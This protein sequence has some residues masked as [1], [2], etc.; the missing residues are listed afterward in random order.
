MHSFL[1]FILHFVMLFMTMTWSLHIFHLFLGITFPF[2]SRFLQTKK[3]KLILCIGELI[4]VI[5]LSAIPPAIFLCISEYGIFWYP[6]SH[7]LPRS[8]LG[9]YLLFLP[10]TILCS[11][12]TN[13][14]IF[15][16]WTLRKVWQKNMLY[17]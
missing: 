16:F 6:P 14:I 13:M 12:G 11:I 5:I 9:I 15:C 8:E 10:V 3:W 4:S 2:W 17:V 7:V 1:G